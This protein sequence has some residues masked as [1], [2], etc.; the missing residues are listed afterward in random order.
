MPF[1]LLIVG[2]L[3]LVVAIQGTQGTAFQM[4]KGEFTGSNSFVV[5][6]SAIIILGAL[7]YIRPIRPIAFGMIAL[8]LL[9]MVLAN[10]GGFFT[11]LNNA[12]RN[13]ITP[14]SAPLT[15]AGADTSTTMVTAPGGFGSLPATTY[16][17]GTP[18][19][20]SFGVLS[21]SGYLPTP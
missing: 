2:V 8:V 14:A 13:P 7:A 17:P 16:A 1:V 21:G 4:L 19:V 12:L 6:A 5:F 11:S 20:P 15:I 9:A 10:K 18:A 3:F